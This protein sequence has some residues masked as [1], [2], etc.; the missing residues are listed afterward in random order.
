[1]EL[2]VSPKQAQKIDK[3]TTNDF[4]LAE[5]ILM[6]LASKSAFDLI[7]TK[8]P[9]LKNT[10][11]L[12]FCGKGNNGGDG[13]VVARWLKNYSVN[14]QIILLCDENEI[15]GLPKEKLELYKKINGFVKVLTSKNEFESLQKPDFIVDA[16]L[17][18]GFHGKLSDFTAEVVKKIN[19]LNTTVFALDVPTGLNGENGICENEAVKSTFTI[20]FGKAKT[21][22][23][24]NSAKNFTGEIFTFDVGF[25]AKANEKAGFTAKLISQSSAC[26]LLPKRNFDAYKNSVGKVFIF[27]GSKGMTGAAILNSKACLKAGCGLVI[28]AVPEDLNAIFEA[29]LIETMTFPYKIFD[30]FAEKI[31]WSDV[32]VVGSGL[33]TSEQTK[34]LFIKF[35]SH[36]KKAEKPTV[37]DADALNIF[38]EQNDLMKNLPENSIFT[39]HFGEFARLTKL[40]LETIR[41]NVLEIGKDF[42]KKHKVTL[43]LKGSPT[44]IFSGN[45]IFV[46]SSGNSGMATAGS[47]DVLTGILGSFLAQK[48]DALESAV[49]GTFLHGFSGDLAKNALTEFSVSAS[50][51]IDFLPK[52]ILMTRN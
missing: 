19:S 28:L 18:T 36:L 49:L 34:E 39:P 38:A 23:Y 42:A 16:I 27:A 10:S 5:T 48:K 2:L 25:P 45:E 4:G 8:I 43:V 40:D 37:F 11:C 46:N 17:G 31:N 24:L 12:V 50:N 14:V 52:A 29:S 33:G 15:Q 20:T 51:L 6:E 22:L 30:G 9:N 13:F 3:I 47:G 26:E 44:V 41:Q 35:V 1:M 21:G 7:K 32:C